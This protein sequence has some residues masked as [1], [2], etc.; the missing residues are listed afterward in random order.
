MSDKI[1]LTKKQVLFITE[2]LDEPNAE[3][4]AE[5]FMEILAEERVDPAEISVYIDKIVIRMV[6]KK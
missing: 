2:M 4:A 6:N 3:R 1:R 5:R